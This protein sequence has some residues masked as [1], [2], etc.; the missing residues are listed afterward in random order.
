MDTDTQRYSLTGK[1][2]IHRKADGPLLIRAN[3][4]G[5]FL[6]WGERLRLWLGLAKLEDL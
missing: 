2:E 4:T 5:H 1:P 3:G 6:T